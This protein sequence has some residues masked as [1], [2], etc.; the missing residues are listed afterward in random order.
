MNFEDIKWPETI[1]ITGIGTH[2]GKSYATG[3]LAREMK[4][5]GHSVITQKAV[6]TGCQD[7]SE[8]IR[9]HR[10]IMGIPLHTFDLTKI[11]APYIF[12]YQASP[13][14]S[15]RLENVDIKSDIISE[16]TRI[17]HRQFKHVLLE[18][19]AGLMA[20]IKGDYLMIDYMREHKLPAILVTNGSFGSISHTLMNLYTMAHYGINI[21]GV[22]YNPHFDFDKKIAEETKSYLKEWVLHHYPNTL[23]FEMPERV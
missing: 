10:K 1:F 19:A 14:L 16:A 2:V 20:P 7:V 18:G 6:Q 8:D 21:F 15:A 11:S 17:M 23:W 22:I 3:W 12:K 9:L 13:H 4:A 5:C